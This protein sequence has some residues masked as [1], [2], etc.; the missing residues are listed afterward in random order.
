MDFTYAVNCVK[1][2]DGTA[3]MI[4]MPKDVDILALGL[5]DLFDYENLMVTDPLSRI[6]VKIRK[7]RKEK[8]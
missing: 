8:K 2:M 1:W 4:G 3:P 5:V 6:L 7:G